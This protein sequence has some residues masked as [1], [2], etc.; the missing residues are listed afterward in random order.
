MKLLFKNKQTKNKK[1]IGQVVWIVA[2]DVNTA[3][4]EILGG[5]NGEIVLGLAC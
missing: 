2:V 3:L 5:E 1:E 4:R